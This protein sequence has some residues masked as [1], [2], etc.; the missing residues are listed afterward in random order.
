MMTLRCYSFIGTASRNKAFEFDHVIVF[1]SICAFLRSVCEP[2]IY[3]T[4]KIESGSTKESQSRLIFL[5]CPVDD[6][7][8]GDSILHKF[9]NVI[10]AYLFDLDPSRFGSSASELDKVVASWK[11]LHIFAEQFKSDT[12]KEFLKKATSAPDAIIGYSKVP[13]DS[14]GRE[15]ISISFTGNNGKMYSAKILKPEDVCLFLKGNDS[16][17]DFACRNFSYD[18]LSAPSMSYDTDDMRNRLYCSDDPSDRNHL[19]Y[20]IYTGIKRGLMLDHF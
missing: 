12:I 1:N 13:N 9:R 6:V 3:F 4:W 20:A 16:K 2:K 17:D 18:L 7:Q 15:I 5:R 19:F 10:D 8:R 11:L 14:I